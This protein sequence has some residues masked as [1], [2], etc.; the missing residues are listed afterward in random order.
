MAYNLVDPANVKS[1]LNQH[2]LADG[3]DITLDLE[4]SE[5]CYLYDS[6]KNRKILDFF[7][8]FTTAPLGHNHPKLHS[9]EEFK[10]NLMLAAIANPSNSD[11]YTTQYATFLDTFSKVA[12]PEQFIYSFF[13]AGGAM[14]VANTLKVAMD[15][16]VQKNM[17][18]GSTTEKGQQ[19]IHFKQAFHGRSGYTLSITDTSSDKTKYFAKFDWPR[20]T[21][22]KIIF[23]IEHH[24]DEVIKDERKA[25][26]E[27][28]SVLSANPDD[29]CAIII[30]PIQSEGG[31]NH[32]R[33]E[34]LQELRT[35]ADENEVMLIFDEVQTGVG[36]TG[37]FWAYQH[38][39]VVPDLVSFGKK[40][41]ICGMIST[42]RVDEI[43]DN[44]FHVSGRINSTWGGN[45]VD[46]VRSTKYL[47]II[48]EDNLVENAATQGKYLLEKIHELSNDYP[49]TN[50][51]GLG[52]QCAFDLKDSE[53]RNKIINEALTH[54]LLLLGCGESSIRFR[55]PLII[56]QTEIDEGIQLIRKTFDVVLVSSATT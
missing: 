1:I 12:L 53:T 23:P 33:K 56:S 3:I 26:A 17:Q 48:E 10:K 55:P 36:I 43:P 34:F 4:K 9:D 46:M 19:I 2:I 18:K 28:K 13:I 40:M 44:C 11:L 29:M 42:N 20:I 6:N 39:N 51:R 47:Q 14:A 32:F 8:F 16:K 5:G 25:I 15:W 37:K 35:L 7:T 49:I 41:Q 38:Y 52:L 27:I 31:D 30:E 45:L 50:V 22:P 21:N 54:D 24:L